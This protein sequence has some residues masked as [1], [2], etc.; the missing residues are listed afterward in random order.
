[1]TSMMKLGFGF[2]RHQLTPENLAFA[3]QVGATHIVVHLVDYFNQGGSDNPR[4]NQPTGSGQGWGVAGGQDSLWN[5]EEL[6]EIKALIEQA[7]LRW[8]A[9]EN[10]DPGHWHDILLDGPKRSRQ[11]ENI[12][13]MVRAVGM[14]GIAV[15]GY[16]FSLAGVTSRITGPFARGGAESVGMQGEVDQTPIPLG[17]VWNMIYDTGAPDGLLP[18]V[19]RAEL[20][21]RFD[22]F[23]SEILPVAESAGVQ[24]AAH[25]E[26]PPVPNLRSQPRL[27]YTKDAYQK[28]LAISDSPAN[29]LEFCLGTLAEMPDG[30][31]YEA[32]D[33]YSGG[34]HLA[35]IHFRNV[36]G[37]AP[38]YHETF[39]DEGDIDLRR[40]LGI[41]DKNGFDGVIIPDH[42]PQMSCDAP[43]H[44]GMAF[45]MGYMAALMGDLQ[46]SARGAS[47]S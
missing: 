33:R 35:Y 34:H 31:L 45:A 47:E 11:I 38:H 41:L 19:T 44:A 14:A 6:L 15:I 7:G 1:M 5:L 8:H 13:S 43:W 36:R 12:K 17:M 21:N 24:L 42:A 23:L 20:W 2:Y 29:K 4:N 25:P 26:D 39:I 37:R 27:L 28:L 30:D 3:R 40:V 22:R 16:N 32:V 18:T 10:F 9:I 46:T